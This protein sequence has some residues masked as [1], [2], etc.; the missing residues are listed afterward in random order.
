MP[1]IFSKAAAVQGLS[2][3]A[4]IRLTPAEA[5]TGTNSRHSKRESDAP[6]RFTVNQVAGH[7]NVIGSPV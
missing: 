3:Q 5:F 4:Y 2:R 1:Q 6:P 7:E